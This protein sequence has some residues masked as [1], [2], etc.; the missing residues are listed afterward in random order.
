MNRNSIDIQKKAF[1][2]IAKLLEL[3][4]ESEKY[5][6]DAGLALPEPLAL[7]LGKDF[8]IDDSTN[9]AGTGGAWKSPE[10]PAGALDTWIS[11][12]MGDLQTSTFVI[13]ILRDRKK[14]HASS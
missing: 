6:V 10:P 9:N 8:S 11:I 7:L 5:F 12:P 3:A 14:N 2:S 13:A 1:E 4:G